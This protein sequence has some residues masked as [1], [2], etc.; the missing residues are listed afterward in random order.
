MKRL[1]R[2]WEDYRDV[3]VL[4][5][6]YEG[7]AAQETWVQRTCDGKRIAMSTKCSFPRRCLGLSVQV[8]QDVSSP[9]DL[10]SFTWAW[11]VE[12][13]FNIKPTDEERALQPK[14]ES[15]V[16]ISIPPSRKSAVM[17]VSG[18]GTIPCKVRILIACIVTLLSWKTFQIY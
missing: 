13:D 7:N 2:T 1:R 14:E 3:S 9:S 12:E 17:G 8:M 11:A 5:N 6:H 10:I 18:S 15:G 16:W 4:L